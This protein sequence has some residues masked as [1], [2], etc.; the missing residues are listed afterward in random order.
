MY[1]A[2]ETNTATSGTRREFIA[3]CTRYL[4][5][6]GG[7]NF[8][9]ICESYPQ[10]QGIAGNAA[11]EKNSNTVTV[12]PREVTVCCVIGGISYRNRH[13]FS[14]CK[15]FTVESYDKI[16]APVIKK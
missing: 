15:L 5:M 13:R 16:N 7:W 4:I 11:D 8:A 1:T 12:L 6:I 9:G 14:D 10:R 2:Q 3:S